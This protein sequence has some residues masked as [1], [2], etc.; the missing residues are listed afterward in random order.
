MYIFTTC[1]FLLRWRHCN[2]IIVKMIRKSFRWD[3]F[4]EFELTFMRRLKQQIFLL[5]YGIRLRNWCYPIE[6]IFLSS[7]LHIGHKNFLFWLWL[8]NVL[9]C[10]NSESKCRRTICCSGCGHR[11]YQVVLQNRPSKDNDLITH[12]DADAT[13]SQIKSL[14][15]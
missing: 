1:N 4:D 3:D 12:V 2:C 15:N 14:S 9:L 11:Q 13:H 6:N 10:K 8:C 5:N 7:Y